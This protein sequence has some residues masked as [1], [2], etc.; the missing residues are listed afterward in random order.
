[1]NERKNEGI[2]KK[3]HSEHWNKITRRKKIGN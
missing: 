2:E 1:V 3:E